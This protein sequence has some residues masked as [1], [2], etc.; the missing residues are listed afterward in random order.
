MSKAVTWLVVLGVV[1]LFVIA[2]T[3]GVSTQDRQQECQQRCSPRMGI[4]RSDPNYPAAP[5]GKI[6]PMI[7]VCQ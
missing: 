4:W 3:K 7:C 1:A 2:V 5:Q 6:V